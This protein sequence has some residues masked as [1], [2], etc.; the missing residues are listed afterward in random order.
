[1]HANVVLW[2]LK[3]GSNKN[4]GVRRMCN[5]FSE[6][7]KWNRGSEVIKHLLFYKEI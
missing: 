5:T 2:R 1:M 4:N 6:D 7:R 3:V